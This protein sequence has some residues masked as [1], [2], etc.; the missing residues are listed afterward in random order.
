MTGVDNVLQFTMVSSS[1]TSFVANAHEN[2]DLFFALRGG[3]G[4]TYGVI[5]SVTYQTHE[6]L[7]LVAAVFSAS[8]NSASPTPSWRNLFT[9]LVKEHPRLSDD[10]W[11]G[12]VSLSP[13]PTTGHLG[14][15]AIYVLVNGTLQAANA[16]IQ[17]FFDAAQSIA[18][19]S[20]GAVTISSAQTIP[21]DSFFDLLTTFFSGGPGTA[22][23]N[24]ATGSWLLPRDVVQKQPEHVAETLV[25]LPN[26][27]ML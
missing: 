14:L 22:G 20:F 17:P 5:T 3:G 23:S 7:P 2:P 24:G 27:V 19:N 8:T 6:N 15:S 11:A 12:F 25:H 13:D 9:E 16:S 26:L 1:G 21:V 10:G 4:G 18:A